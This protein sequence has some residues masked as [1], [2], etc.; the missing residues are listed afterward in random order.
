[1][2]DASGVD[3]DWFWRGWFY[4]TDHVDVAI[5]SIREYKVSSAD[6]EVEFELNRQERTD[7]VP[8]TLGQIRNREEGRETRLERF[9][10]LADL[11]NDDDPHTVTNA[12][13]NKYRKLLEELD[14]WE[15]DAL[16]RA[17][18]DDD[19]VY[20]VDFENVG[21]LVTP[22]PL[23][24]TDADGNEEFMMI[25]AE[26]W[27]RNNLNVTKLLI[28]DTPIVSIEVDPRRETA[29]VDFSNNHFPRRIERSRLELYKKDDETRDMM[30]DMLATLRE[31]KVGDN[32]SAKAVPLE[33]TGNE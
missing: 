17:V 16:L 31:V 6:P 22:L 21:G 18:A 28:R 15:R 24:I 32:G 25:P 1:M 4:S 33:S 13:R 9:P 14:D 2:E 23:T 3:L 7:E 26:I 29:D 11:Y 5:N 27:R 20:F 12:D 8:E 30:A 19:F 10:E